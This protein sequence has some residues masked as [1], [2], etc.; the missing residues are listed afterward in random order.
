M[1]I[2]NPHAY[3]VCYSNMDLCAQVFQSL[4][5]EIQDDIVDTMSKRESEERILREKEDAQ[6]RDMQG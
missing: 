6:V 5:N 2:T 1:H 4:L 3:E